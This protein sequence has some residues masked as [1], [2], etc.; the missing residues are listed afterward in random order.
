M[1]EIKRYQPNYSMCVVYPH[2][3]LYREKLD[4]E[5]V[6]Y[7]DYAC[8]AADLATEREKNARLMEALDV[9]SKPV[10]VH[11]WDYAEGQMLLRVKFAHNFETASL[12]I[13]ARV[14][15]TTELL[16]ARVNPEPRRKP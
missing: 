11:E 12:L 5:F 10:S 1:S 7:E 15:E 14:S 2:L 8:L 3:V 9:M 6:R 13:D 4:G 16:A